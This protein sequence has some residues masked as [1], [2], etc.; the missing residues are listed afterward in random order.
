MN[1]VQPKPMLHWSL[2]S[3][4][5]LALGLSVTMWALVSLVN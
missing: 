1:R 3:R 5:S 4:F 2:L